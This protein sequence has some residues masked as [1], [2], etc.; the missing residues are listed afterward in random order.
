[1][2]EQARN[3]LVAVIKTH[4]TEQD[5]EF[6]NCLLIL[7]RAKEYQHK[8]AIDEVECLIV[9]ALECIEKRKDYR[10]ASSK[11]R[12]AFK[13]LTSPKPADNEITCENCHYGSVV[14]CREEYGCPWCEKNRKPKQIH[15]Q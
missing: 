11:L 10:L 14:A 4:G 12:E 15:S 1:M 3:N 8:Q 2:D 6:L 5:I 9:G 13:Y 7:A